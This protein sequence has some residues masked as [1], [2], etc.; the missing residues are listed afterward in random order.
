[1]LLGT[2]L[3]LQLKEVPP[4]SIFSL[5]TNSIISFSDLQAALII[6]GEGRVAS[7]EVANLS[8]GKPV[9]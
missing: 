4:L 8:V 3:S 1:M 5:H 6:T 7:L 2:K 9:D